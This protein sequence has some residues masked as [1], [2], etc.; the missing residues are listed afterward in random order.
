VLPGVAVGTF[1]GV[2][3]GTSDD[4]PVEGT[5]AEGVGRVAVEFTVGW[6]FF[7][8]GRTTFLGVAVGTTVFLIVGML[9][10]DFTVGCAVA[11]GKALDVG[12]S[13]AV[14]N[15]LTVGSGLAGVTVGAVFV[16]NDV[17]WRFCFV[18]GIVFPGVD[19]GAIVAMGRSAEVGRFVLLV[20]GEGVGP[21]TGCTVG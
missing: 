13:L 11:V 1:A 18:G 14:G 2:S 3:V 4:E 7:G 15:S 16:G 12:N 6:S 21:I 8:V 10:V 5:S 20:P 9:P 17:G 19:V